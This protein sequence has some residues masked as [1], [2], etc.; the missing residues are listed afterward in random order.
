MALAIVLCV[1]TVLGMI[2]AHFWFVCVVQVLGLQMA[3]STIISYTM[4]ICV[5]GACVIRALGQS[6][7]L[8]QMC[9][10]KIDRVRQE[11]LECRTRGGVQES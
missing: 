7:H 4:S 9:F 8:L 1:I 10:H 6:V 5:K 2:L 11:Q 3:K